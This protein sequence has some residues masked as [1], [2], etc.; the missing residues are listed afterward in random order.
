M[1]VDVP[2]LRAMYSRYTGDVCGHTTCYAC[3]DCTTEWR[4]VAEKARDSPQLTLEQATTLPSHEQE[5]HGRGCQY[6]IPKAA[7]FFYN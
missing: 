2:P 1:N 3:Q 7:V 6:A 4:Y 5:L